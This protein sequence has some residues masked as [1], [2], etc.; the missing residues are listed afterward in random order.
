MS[1][2]TLVHLNSKGSVKNTAVK[3]PKLKTLHSKALNPRAHP[4]Q[5]VMKEIL[6]VF[7]VTTFSVK[8]NQ[9]ESGCSTFQAHS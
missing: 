6:L 5:L 1:L 3:S 2:Y 9:Y 7:Q 8:G 4:A